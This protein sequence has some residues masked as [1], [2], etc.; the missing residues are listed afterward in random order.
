MDRIKILYVHSSDELYGADVVLLQLLTNLDRERFDPLVILPNDVPYEGL[1]SRELQKSGIRHKI[2]R[3]G[4][5]RRKYFHPLGSLRYLAYLFGSTLRL[6]RI[7]RQ[8]KI[9]L[10]HS[11]T[12]AVVCGALA[13]AVTGTPHVWHVHEIIVKP[14]LLRRATARMLVWFSDE[15]V[16][17]SGAVREHLCSTESALHTKTRVIHNCT[18][19]ER[20]NSAGSAEQV[21]SEFGVSPGDLLVG[22]VGRISHWKGQEL[23]LRA[24]AE[25]AKRCRRA[26]FV[27][28]GGTF[29]GQ[30]YRVQ[31]LSDM[32]DSLGLH[33]RVTISGFRSDIPDVLAAFD[34]VILPSTQPEP[35]SVVVLEAMASGKPVI[36]T[37]HGG[38]MESVV[39]RVTGYLVTP[40]DAKAMAEATVCLLEKPAMRS[41]M[42][43]AGRRRAEECFSLDRFACQFQELYEEQTARRLRS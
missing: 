43:A 34:V 29:P 37:A 3:L 35:F 25:V 7:I 18:D 23:F 36:A 9:A 2:L 40:G 39:D 22:M 31:Q 15:V 27:L 8:E 20:F 24:A 21:R 42:G 11:N 26:K 12:L 14:D 4:V 5:L 6:I 30:E 33:D 38:I 32:V 16:A 13:C 10:V 28:V 1:L 17:V 41:E 19:L